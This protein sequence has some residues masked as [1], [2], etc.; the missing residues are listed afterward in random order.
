MQRNIQL[1]PLYVI[2][3]NMMAW[4]PV[5]FLFFNQHLSLEQVLQL[6]AL[7]YASVVLLEVPSGYFSDSIGRRPTLLISSVAF[8]LSYGLFFIG[9]NFA[10]F[11][12]AQIL[13]AVGFAFSSGTDTSFH[14]DSLAAVNQ[15]DQYGDRE[16]K[17]A[18]NGFI[19][20]AVAIFLGGLVGILALR[21]AYGIS[22]LGAL[23]A[24]IVVF[25][26]KEPTL[27]QDVEAP[28]S[29][30]GNQLRLTIGY[31]QKPGLFWLFAFAILMT[32]L[33]HIPYEFY[34]PYINLLGDDIP[35]LANQ[36]SLVAGIVMGVS[37]LLGAFAAGRS[38][39]LSDQIGIGATLLLATSLQTFLILMMGLALNVL[40]IPFILLRAVPFGLMRAPMNAAIAPQV[41]QAQR[42]TYLSIQS[43]AG[44]LAFSAT[45]IGLAW[46]AGENA[47]TDWPTL[48]TMLRIGAVIGLVGLGGLALSRRT[49]ADA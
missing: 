20:S 13:L 40:I 21:Y 22:F 1:Y 39:W 43:L 17:V 48:A 5:F 11:A 14:Y 24:V 26:F 42:A 47:N 34:Q 27:R 41:A 29:G 4:L 31:L 30:F 25:F 8:S 2:F 33:N 49:L 23:G 3:F 16:A 37:M 32:I 35:L 38:I 10:I 44:R 45:L 9:D 19:A 12:V 6:E 28:T 15:E 18:R 46:I 7:Y 36:T